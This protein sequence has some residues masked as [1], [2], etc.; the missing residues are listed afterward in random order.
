MNERR[1]QGKK[2]EVFTD[3]TQH[4]KPG[5]PAAGILE[6]TELVAALPGTHTKSKGF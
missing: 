3:S 6:A 1:S 4:T 2:S 5:S